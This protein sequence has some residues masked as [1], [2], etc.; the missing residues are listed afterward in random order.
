VRRGG[1]LLLLAL[2]LLAT[3]GAAQTADTIAAGR[4]L[5]DSLSLERAV[6]LFR[7]VTASSWSLP[8]STAERVTALE[9]LGASLVL[10]NA[11][12]SALA[13]F[14]AA[15]QTDPFADLDPLRFTPAQVGVFHDAQD[16]EFAVAVRP[17]DSVRID[18]RT[19]SLALR[20]FS[21]H[22]ATL[23]VSLVTPDQRSLV[24]YA[25]PNRGLRQI[26]WDALLADGSFAGAGRYEVRV[27]GTSTIRNQ[28]DSA[29]IYFDVKLEGPGLSDTL[30]SLSAG[31]LVPSRYGGAWA[32]RDALRALTVALG[33]VA[34]AEALPNSRVDGSH[35]RAGVVAGAAILAGAGTLIYRRA[36]PDLARAVAE[37]ARRNAARAARNAQIRREN[38][39]R[40]NQT[41]L[42]IT[43]AA[44]AA[45]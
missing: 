5:Y 33:A 7:R 41:N 21:T 6:P 35:A 32:R 38:A 17:V 15:I 2:G 25:G 29:R 22:S 10:L 3:R 9:Y 12:D 34:L 31:D 42:I 18:P 44:G 20:V 43:P 16:S 26:D 30:P 40:L 1:A 23:R 24:L 39:T 11:R 36:H 28:A 13:A 45:P 8:V 4:Q 19:G 27:A 14:R 37:N